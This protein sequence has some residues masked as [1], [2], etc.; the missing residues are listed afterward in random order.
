MPGGE[1]HAERVEE[2]PAAHRQHRAHQH[3]AQRGAAAERP[4]GA[5]EEQRAGDGPAEQVD[6]QQVEHQDGD[7]LADGHPVGRDRQVD[8]L[9]LLGLRDVAARGRHGQ[10]DG[11]HDHARADQVGEEPRTDGVA[12]ADGEAARVDDRVDPDRAERGREHVLR[13]VDGLLAGGSGGSVL[14]G[15]LGRLAHISPSSSRVPDTRWSCSSMNVAKSSPVL[16]SS[17]QPLSS[18]TACHSGVSCM[19]WR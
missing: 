2:V 7:Q 8:V 19:V 13:L 5:G 16:K 11:E 17:V 14:A 9:A 4:R 6:Q 1:R 3:V 18:S 10:Q 12:E 15:R